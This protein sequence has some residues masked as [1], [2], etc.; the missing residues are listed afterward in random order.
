MPHALLLPLHLAAGILHVDVLGFVIVISTLAGISRA[1]LR[2]VGPERHVDAVDAFRPRDV[3]QGVR[4]KP[5]RGEPAL[6]RRGGGAFLESE[7]QH[8]IW[9]DFRIV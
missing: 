6:N 7:W 2:I 5:P 8:A 4:S 1:G 3:L 9:C